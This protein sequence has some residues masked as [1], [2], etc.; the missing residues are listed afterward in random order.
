MIWGKSAEVRNG[1]TEHDLD[2][3]EDSILVQRAQAGDREAF[4][5]LIRR[6]R[7]QVYGYAQI[8]TQESFLAED[9]VQ[10]A[11]IR[12][13]LHLGTLVDV[14]RFLP[15]LHR[16][17]RNQAYS[18]LRRDPILKESPFSSL[19]RSGEE[20]DPTGVVWSNL[21]DILHR[22]SRS[23]AEHANTSAN[24]EV[25]L[26][27]RQ[28]H[29]MITSLLSCLSKRERQIF[30]SH[31]FEHL[32][33]QEIAKLFSLSPANVYQILSRSRKKVAKERIRIVVDQYITERKDLGALK[34]NLLPKTATFHA[35]GTW[36]SVGWAFYRM[37]SFTDQQLSLPMVMGLTGQAFRMTICHND[38]HI[39]GPTMYS[40]RDI[41]ARGLQNIGWSSRIVE[42]P[43]MQDGPGEN[44]SL[45][46]PALLTAAAKEKRPIQ[47]KL[48]AALDLIHRSIDRGI[49]VLSWDL[50]IPEFGVI[51]GYDDE[52]RILT[53]MACMQDDKLPYDHLGRG[54]LEELF[55]LA[56]EERTEKDLRSMFRDALM[57][58]LDHYHGIE[59]PTDRG[60]RGLRAYD[61]WIDAFHGGKI[62][63]NG[64]AY[65]MEVVQDARRLAAE[66]LREICAKWQGDGESY[67]RMRAL[68]AEA[69]QVYQQMSEELQE[70]V[71]LFPFPAGGDPNSVVNLERAVKVLQSVKALEEQAVSLLEQMN[72]AI[73]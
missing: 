23:F 47:E 51:Y 7:R 20:G 53:A 70:L 72:A 71:V 13:F 25:H 67:K 55:I 8:L 10:D 40:F 24:P 37:L 44:A 32:S 66:F 69:A 58:I 48:P 2:M 6:H 22:V 19:Q 31:F 62:E 63:P 45:L 14:A 16:I 34:T 12:A 15:W 41:L 3:L 28:L 11:L 38:V 39:A 36:T 61:V 26:M 18:R 49:P 50:F 46:D 68:S 64:N 56:L 52:Q 57:M 33:P 30:E 42:T 60:E 59:S 21:D 1:E 43:N 65:N 9:I 35:P 17:V 4:G 29:E 27:R 73:A 5:E 54:T